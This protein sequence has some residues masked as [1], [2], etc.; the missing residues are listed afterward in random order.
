[1]LHRQWKSILQSEF[2]Q[3]FFANVLQTGGDEPAHFS[4]L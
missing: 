3:N 1:M 2:P 4:P